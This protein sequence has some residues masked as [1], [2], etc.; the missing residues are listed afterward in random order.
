L[1]WVGIA[2]AHAGSEGRRKCLL[3]SLDGDTRQQRKYE[4]GSP[5]FVFLVQGR[6]LQPNVRLNRSCS[7]TLNPKNPSPKS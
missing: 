5:G 4:G 7:K 6:F 1:H 3:S 2:G